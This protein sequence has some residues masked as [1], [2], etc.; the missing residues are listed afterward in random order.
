MWHY[1]DSAPRGQAWKAFLSH[2]RYAGA[3][4]N[5][6]YRYNCSPGL[7][8]WVGEKNLRQIS[9]FTPEILPKFRDLHQH[10]FLVWKG[11]KGVWAVRRLEQ[12]KAGGRHY[13][14]FQKLSL[15]VEHVLPLSYIAAWIATSLQTVQQLIGAMLWSAWNTKVNTHGTNIYICMCMNEWIQRVECLCRNYLLSDIITYPSAH[16]PKLRHLRKDI[17]KDLIL[18]QT[19]EHDIIGA[20][21]PLTGS[22][23][24]RGQTQKHNGENL[25]LTWYFRNSFL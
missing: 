18:I 4:F 21:R 1:N 3:N 2:Q 19:K 10:N 11:P 6:D 23:M 25:A 20:S 12:S 7:A 16:W 5:P 22:P 8:T 13:V 24:L 15:V 17:I 9:A 14:T